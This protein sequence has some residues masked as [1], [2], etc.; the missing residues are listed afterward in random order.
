MAICSSDCKAKHGVSVRYDATNQPVIGTEQANPRRKVTR[1]AL[2]RNSSPFWVLKCKLSLSQKSQINHIF[3]VCIKPNWNQ[4]SKIFK[5]G[6]ASNRYYYGGCILLWLKKVFW[7][8]STWEDQSKCIYKKHIYILAVSQQVLSMVSICIYLVIVK[9]TKN[10]YI[11]RMKF[12][13]ILD[14]L[15]GIS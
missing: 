7:I 11:Q 4:R 15:W 10:L 8:I 6:N 13:E 3:D 12:S 9:F 5:M 2:I 14:R 1:H